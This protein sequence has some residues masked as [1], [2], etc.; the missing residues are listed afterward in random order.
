M[1]KNEVPVDTLSHYLPPGTFEPVAHYLH[2]YRVH[3]TITRT[4]KSILGDYRHAHSNKNHRISVNGNLN[5]Y[6]FLL[7]LL[8]E[9]AHL[10]AFDKYGGRVPPHGKEWQGVFSVLIRQFLQKKIFP[11]DITRALENSIHRPAASSCSDDDL[12]RI[13]RRYDPATHKKL[14]EQI[15]LGGM[16][17]TD[18]NRIFQR[19]DVLRKRYVCNEMK[20]GKTFLFSPIYEVTPYES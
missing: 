4:R 3:L 1:T 16:F 14:V 5:P 15:P 19:G 11:D 20:T 17:K 2:E 6:A 12:M 13:L 7:T 10:L 8:H 9:L 18:D